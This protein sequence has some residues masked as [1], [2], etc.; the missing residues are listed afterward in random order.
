MKKKVFFILFMLI[1]IFLILANIFI[2]TPVFSEQ[3][4]R[5]LAKFP[6]FSWDAL[7]SGEYAKQLDT[8]I[9]D[10]FVFRDQWLKLESLEEIIQGKT[11][12]NDVYIGKEGS[13]F[14]KFQMTQTKWNHLQDTTQRIKRFADK[15]DVPSYML[16]IPNAIFI[17]PEKLPQNAVVTDQKEVINKTYEELRNT[18]QTIDVSSCLSKHKEEYLYFKTDHHMTSD[19]AYWVYEQF[20]QAVGIVPRQKQEWN[21]IRVSN[22][23]LGTL[24][25]K[26]QRIGQESDEIVVYQSQANLT[27]KQVDY[28]GKIQ[29]SIFAPEYLEKKDKYSYFLNGNN[30]KIVIKTNIQNAKKIL[31]IKDSYAHNFIPFLCEHYEEIHVIDP[32]YYRASI[33]EYIQKQK[34]TEC[35]FLYNVSNFVTD[36]GLRSLT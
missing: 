2:K 25:S 35:L 10:H 14:E 20:C 34:V 32:R 1:W 8:Y 30:A 23:F 26:V 7:V 29:N 11:E 9:N 4:N 5:M 13:L 36:L 24:D 33:S 15:L 27:L 18:V 21:R 16:L 31:I 6:S 22:S 3:E 12:H 28:D 17:Y 19:G